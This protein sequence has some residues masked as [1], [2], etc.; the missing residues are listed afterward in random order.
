MCPKFNIPHII[1]L[2]NR[3]K[4][5]GKDDPHFYKWG[6]KVIRRNSKVVDIVPDIT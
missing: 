3:G 6:F 1:V 4:L 2:Y 5:T